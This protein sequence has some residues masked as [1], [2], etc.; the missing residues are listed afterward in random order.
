MKKIRSMA[1]SIDMLLLVPI[2]VGTLDGETESIQS[3][4]EICSSG[5]EKSELPLLGCVG[6]DG[7]RV[8]GCGW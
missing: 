8:R 3:G 2:V 7:R 4:V 5:T 1:I 6:D